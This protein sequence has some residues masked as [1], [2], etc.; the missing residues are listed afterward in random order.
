MLDK[1][2]INENTLA[3]IP[4]GTNQSRIIENYL[5]VVVNM[6]PTEIINLSCLY[7]GS[8][9]KGRCES[10][11]YYLGTR[12][13]NPIIVNEFPKI[14]FF[15]TTSFKNIDCMWLN[16]CGIQKFYIAKDNNKSTTIELINHKLLTI[17][18]TNRIICNQF[19]KSSR[20]DSIYKSKN[21]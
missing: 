11:A 9:L 3:I 7:F 2:V 1:Y 15:P 13:K 16:Y 19:L 12:Y 10:S 4:E 14:I 5:N 17:K 21:H 20:L 6:L 18:T 8:S